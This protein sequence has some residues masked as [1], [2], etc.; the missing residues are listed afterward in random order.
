MAANDPNTIWNAYYD[1]FGREPASASQ[2]QSFSRSNAN[3][4]PLAFKNA[5]NLFKLNKGKGHIAI[6]SS[7]SSPK[8]SVPSSTPSKRVPSKPPRKPSPPSK[9]TQKNT[10]SKS[11]K[12]KQSI[13]SKATIT[14]PKPKPNKPKKLTQHKTK[15]IKQTKPQ[16]ST[17]RSSLNNDYSDP[18]LHSMLEILRRATLV[19]KQ[20]QLDK[21]TPNLDGTPTTS[22]DDKLVDAPGS[23]LNTDE[24]CKSPHALFRDDN[25]WDWTKQDIVFK[26]SLNY[27]ISLQLLHLGLTQGPLFPNSI[28]K[29]KKLQFKENGPTPRTGHVAA[30]MNDKMVIFGGYAKQ[31]LTDHIF[32]VDTNGFDQNECLEVTAISSLEKVHKTYRVGHSGVALSHSLYLFGG[33]NDQQYINNGLLFYVDTLKLVDERSKDRILPAPRRDHTLCQ[34]GSGGL[35][36]FGGWSHDYDGNELWL[37]GSNWKWQQLNVTGTAPCPRR[38]HTANVI[39]S[40]MFIFGGLYGFSKYLNDLHIYNGDKSEWIQPELVGNT[41]PPPRAWHTSNTVG[42]QILFFGG[43]SG[44]IN[45]MNECWVFDTMGYFWFQIECHGKSPL[46]RCSHSMVKIYQDNQLISDACPVECIRINKEDTDTR[47]TRLA[48]MMFGGLVAV[49]DVQDKDKSDEKKDTKDTNEKKMEDGTQT[50]M[51][52]KENKDM[53]MDDEDDKDKSDEKKDTKDTNEKKMEDGTQ[54]QMEDKENKD[55][56]VDDEDNKEKPEGANQL[57]VENN[58][59]NEENQH[60]NSALSMDEEISSDSEQEEEMEHVNRIELSDDLYVLMLEI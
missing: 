28:L 33:W 34:M 52:D 29:W 43:T 47:E 10:T 22:D 37:L 49:D 32:L 59:W 1:T 42:K 51:E 11:P 40:H 60:R 25:A 57:Q 41:R 8:K 38:G 27:G 24:D 45:F 55:M 14:K 30:F 20:Q 12:P 9:Q 26:E 54:T 21:A 39:G 44:R 16:P 7:A 31:M 18:L 50:Q 23:K 46:P 19:K 2:L 13:P 5:S 4:T 36:L 53:M 15:S 56:M 58:G 3:V 35:L 6:P 17:I 48:L